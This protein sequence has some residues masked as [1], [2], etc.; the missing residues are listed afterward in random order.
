MPAITAFDVSK[1]Y[2]L[3]HRRP[4]YLTFRETLADS[5]GRLR[6]LGSRSSGPE[7]GSEEFWALRD[8][9]FQVDEGDRLAIIGRNGAGKS[10][11]LK[12]L[13]RITEPTTGTIRIRGRCAS[14]LEVGTGFH[15][16]LTG[17]ENILLNGAILGMTRQEIRRRFD[18]IVAFAEVERFL[19]TPV[20]R[21]SSGMYVRLAFAVAAHLEPDILVIDEVL[22][23]GDAQ[24]QK[25]C[26]GRMEQVGREGRTVIFVSHSMQTVLSLCN[27]GILLDQGR[28]AAS[29]TAQDAVT[30]Y[31]ELGTA[32]RTERTWAEP[33]QAPGNEWVRI[34]HV[35]V[36]A[37]SGTGDGHITVRTPLTIEVVFDVH[38]RAES[39]FP[40]ARL[41]TLYGDVIFGSG[42]EPVP[43]RPGSYRAEC[44]IPGDLLNDGMYVIDISFVRDSAVLL[45]RA[46]EILT[47]E[48]HDI[49][50]LP[51]A[52]L[53]K[54][55]G[56]I[57]PRLD[58]ELQETAFASESV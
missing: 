1:R 50:R 5:F 9:N 42:P 53:G 19:D 23:V 14:L 30:A 41:R 12:I 22:S 36:R 11:L 27:R 40:G 44:R 46:E 58:W 31:R 25:K 39:F 6:R 55:P 52:W 47:F 13:S 2:V 57:R 18:E 43:I 34:R 24:F 54:I 10:T 32:S 7:E 4:A 51:G 37:D 21:Y 56:A 48:V 35:S 29:G 33:G 17:R 15:P 3:H 16:E 8:I 49:E 45:Y 20:K 26:L 38:I 28:I